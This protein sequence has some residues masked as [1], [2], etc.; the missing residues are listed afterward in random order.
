MDQTSGDVPSPLLEVCY[1]CKDSYVHHWIACIN[2]E[3]CKIWQGAYETFSVAFQNSLEIS[4]ASGH[5]DPWNQKMIRHWEWWLDP[6]NVLQGEHLHPKENEKLIFTDA[7]NTGQNSTG[8]IWSLSEKHLHINLLE[9]KAVLLALQFFKTDCR[10]IQ[11][12]GAHLVSPKQCHTQSK[13]CTGLTQCD[14]RRPLKEEPDSIN[15]V[16]SVSADF[17]INFQTLG[18]S[19]SGPV[20]NQ[21]EQ[22]TSYL[23]L[24][25]SGSSG[26]QHSVGKHGCLRIPSHCPAAQGCTKTSITT[27]RIILIAPGFRTWWRCLWTFQD[28]YH[29]HALC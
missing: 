8:G 13:A 28:N 11:V 19:P 17:Q 25:D 29:P 24:S 23:Y 2:R 26:P 20:R 3:D 7:S 27:C 14:S 6:Q 22:K 15:R 10:N 5:T 12:L 16:V 18:E 1:Q 21:P 9:M 4:D